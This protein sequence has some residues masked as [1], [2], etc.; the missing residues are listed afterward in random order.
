ML[1]R[2]FNL[3]IDFKKAESSP[4]NRVRKF[5]LDNERYRYLFPE[6][7]PLLLSV[8]EGKRAHFRLLVIVALGLRLRNREQLNLR[9]GQVDFSQCCYCDSHEAKEEPRIPRDVLNPEVREILTTACPGKV[10]R[11]M[12]SKI[13]IRTSRSTTVKR[14]FHTVCRLAGVKNFRWY[15]FRAVRVWRSLTMRH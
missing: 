7:E 15:D 13:L 8:V 3:A 10:L 6:E 9:W 5:K 11:I 2:V 4:C 12:S 1:S 14:S